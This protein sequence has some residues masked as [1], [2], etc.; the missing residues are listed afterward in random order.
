HE[1]FRKAVKADLTV[2]AGVDNLP[3]LPL[4]V[5]IETFEGRPALVAELRL[6]VA[7][8]LPPMRALQAATLNAARVCRAERLLGTV[9]PGKLADLVVAAGDPLTDITAVGDIRLVMKGGSIVRSGYRLGKGQEALD[10]THE[11]SDAWTLHSLS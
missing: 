1:A 4:S 11:V 10:A 3:R 6:M 2:I 7:N 8:G 5:G 9:E